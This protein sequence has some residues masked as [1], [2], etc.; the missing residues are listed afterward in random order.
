[1]IRLNSKRR[2]QLT[3]YGLLF[4]VLVLVTLVASCEKLDASLPSKGGKNLTLSFSADAATRATPAECFTKLHLM[5]FDQ[6]GSKAFTQAKTQNA[7]DESFGTFSISVGEGTYTV[8]AVGHSSPV[9]A[10]IKSL[11]QVT[12]TASDG[13]KLTDTFCYVGQAVVGSSPAHYD[14]TMQRV[15]AMLRFVFTDSDV[16]ANLARWQFS[17]TGGSANFNPSS[18]EGCTK[19]TQSEV[20][21]L[22]EEL[23]IYTFPYLASDGTLKV[24]VSALDAAGVILRQ[25]VFENIPVSRNRITTYR[26]TFFEDGDGQITQS[27]LGFTVNDQ[28][29][30]EDIID[31]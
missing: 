19:S 31:F 27:G 20:R 9:A 1:M 25:R 21:N 24:T 15:C 14:C 13:R 22:G 29:E 18:S 6:Y 26:G 8:V 17:Y 12:F 11:Q 2:L 3:A 7:G 16:P 4:F 23:E 30:G 10:S 5:L 28:W